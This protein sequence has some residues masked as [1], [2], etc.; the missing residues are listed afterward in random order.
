[1]GNNALFGLMA[2]RWRKIASQRRFALNINHLERR[3]HP[4]DKWEGM[5]AKADCRARLYASELAESAR[6]A[7]PTNVFTR[8]HPRTPSSGGALTLLIS[9]PG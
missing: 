5:E 9:I 8:L 4:H 3:Y 2:V 7:G 6:S 1:V